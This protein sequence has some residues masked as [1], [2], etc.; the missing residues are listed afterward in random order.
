MRAARRLLRAGDAGDDA[1]AAA[2]GQGP[3]A[4]AGLD[5]TEVAAMFVDAAVLVPRDEWDAG[6]AGDGAVALS[7]ALAAIAALA[8]ELAAAALGR[9]SAVM[10]MPN[11]VAVA[12]GG[13]GLTCFCAVVA[14]GL[15]DPAAWIGTEQADEIAD[16]LTRALT[17][18]IRWGTGE[19]QLEAR[20]R[21]GP[22]ALVRRLGA[23]GEIDLQAACWKWLN[24]ELFNQAIG[25]RQVVSGFL[26]ELS[27]AGSQYAVEDRD[28]AAAMRAL[29][30]RLAAEA[31]IV[32]PD[33]A[34]AAA[35]RLDVEARF[36]VY[37]NPAV[38]LERARTWRVVAE[39]HASAGDAASCLVAAERVE[40][41]VDAD[42]TGICDFELERARAWRAIASARVHAR[43]AAGC[44]AAAERI[45]TIADAGF[46]GLHDFELERARG[47]GAVTYVSGKVV[48][49]GDCLSAA[50]RVDTV[51]DTG[52]V[53][54]H[55]FELV[56]AE[57]WQNV[58]YVGAI[59]GDAAGCRAAVERVEAVVNG[60]FAGACSFEL[61]RA[62]A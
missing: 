38:E 54:A 26:A 40:T 28:E 61:L 57:A 55:R 20:M 34:V 36:I 6:E 35:T 53:G 60:G 49:V 62:E 24:Q 3:P 19:A 18:T 51:V 9:F 16:A 37:R 56:R 44:F 1:L 32:T 10:D 45:G 23:A 59:A 7:S 13:A 33:T 30:L 22:A 17:Q 47:W 21:D 12:R 25:I 48:D 8:P 2:L 41:V 27:E 58:A 5:A 29:C 50:E 42:F 14:Q 31:A 39:A 11:A 52:F 4:E 46:A 15:K 43:D